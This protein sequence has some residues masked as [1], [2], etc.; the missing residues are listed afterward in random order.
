MTHRARTFPFAPRRLLPLVVILLL[1]IPVAPW[2]G[3]R[4]ASAATCPC[5]IWASSATPAVL[6]DSDTSAVEL[7]VKFRS[8]VRGFVTALRFY[9]G[10]GNNGTH[11][12]S[13]WSSAGVKLA[14]ATFTNETASGWQQVTFP[15]PVAVS[16]ATTYIASYYA[17]VGRYSVTNNGFASGVDNAPLHALADGVNG[18]N[19]IYRYGTGGGFPT[20]T[21]QATNYWVDVAFDTS[22]TDTT[23]PTL[24]ARTPTAGSTGVPVSSP[25][26]GTFSEPVTG[27]V[28]ALTGPAGNVPG[29]TSYD[30]ANQTVTFQ[31]TAALALSAT[32][33]ATVSAAK[34]AAGNTMA[35]TSWSFT[36]A[37]TA[38]GC[39]C[40]LWPSTTTPARASD[41]DN[42]AVEVGT[43]FS[44]STNG[45]VTALRFYKGSANVGTHVGHLWTASGSLLST[46]TF[47]G[48]TATGWQQVT[49]PAPVAVSAGT[50]YVASYFAPVGGYAVNNSYFAVARSSS[51]LQA[52]ADSAGT[53]NGVY[54]YGG[55]AFPSSTFQSSNYWVDVVFDTSAA[56][57]T[58]PTVTSRSPS[59]GATG[60]GT[61]TSVT[62]SFNEP[63]QGSTVVFT[64]SGP[65]GQVPSSV[66][67]DGPG[68]TATLTPS[69]LLAASTSY[70]ASVS[71]SDLAGNAMSAPVTWSF[72]TA[73]V[74]PPPPPSTG[75]VLVVPPTGFGR[76]LPEILRAEGLSEFA[77]GDL[78]ALTSANLAGYDVL[79]LGETPLSAAQVSTLTTWVTGG[80][81][82]IAMRPDKQL[83]G[84]LGL[85]ATLTTLADGY[86]LVNTGT[87]PGVGITDQVIQFHG[88]AD[89][90][91]SNGATTVATLYSNATTATINPAVTVRNVGT[92]GGQAAA[93]TYDLARSVV[94]TRQGNPAFAGLERDRLAPIRSDDLF[95]GSTATSGYLNLNKVAI[96]QAD[97][98]QRLL[99]NLI[100]TVNR[101]KKP[102][103]RFWYLPRMAK[104]VVVG[105]GDDHAN[106]GTA[107]RFDQYQSLSTPGCSV[108][109]WT[110]LR[111]TSYIYP[112]S[113]LTN[114]QASGYNANGFEVALHPQNGC[115]DYTPSSLE[116]D[117]ATQ[118]ASWQSTYTSLPAPTTSRYHCLVWS[119]WASQP[120][121]EA[122]HGIGLDANYYY[123]PGSWLGDRPG[124]MTGSGM[125]MHFADTDGSVIDVYQATTQ[126]T[127]ESGQSY[128]ATPDTLLNNAL[129]PLG[130]YG[131]FT[132]NMH[133]DNPTTF[134][135][136]QLISSAQAHGVSIISS[137]QMLTWL[138]GRNA[139]SFSN[140]TWSGNNLTFTV[141]PATGSDGLSVLLPTASPTGS[142]SGLT[143][144][145]VAV[146]YTSQR[147]KGLDYATFTGASGDYTATYAGAAAAAF[148]QSRAGMGFQKAGLTMEAT[149][150]PPAVSAVSV[151][152]LPDGTANAQW[153]TS[154]RTDSAVEL[155]Q[156][157]DALTAA[158][159]NPKSVTDHSVVVTGLVPGTTYFYRVR[160]TDSAGRTAT[161]SVHRF[162]QSAAGVADTT[163]VSFRTGTSDSATAVSSGR[164]GEIQLAL[165]RPST[166][167]P[168]STYLSRV[169]DSQQMVVW[170]R[171]TWQAS[172]PA[173]T[174]LQVSVRTGSRLLPDAT[175]TP[176]KAM[177]GSGALIRSAGR[178]VQYQVRMTTTASSRTPVLASIGFTHNGTLGRVEKEVGCGESGSTCSPPSTRSS[179]AVPSSFD[180]PKGTSPRTAGSRTSWVLTAL[181]LPLAVRPALAPHGRRGRRTRRS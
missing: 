85:T 136:D 158:G 41:S 113:P 35:T 50:A 179:A 11:V 160:S 9:K 39:P 3:V 181:L 118:L 25:V 97:E 125:P 20:N 178:Y 19:G 38:G 69:S 140:L 94:Y 139:S 40:S 72:T 54:R 115:H 5:T 95:W 64:L 122:A 176:F 135:D 112:N 121:T 130:Y 29:S 58:P 104:A 61:S 44:S 170:D 92:N 17:P 78:S 111:T 27:A 151:I 83:A 79:V 65:G 53:P 62:A 99:V 148:S 2:L 22:S 84:L 146:A 31:P 49:L 106:G 26:S 159:N 177:S 70:T 108:V 171:V 67:V 150:A 88:T 162:V 169:L 157:A 16:A 91:L 174:A 68:T 86:E 4:L 161:S 101:D 73:A 168:S 107:G 14:S 134:Q 7:G 172:V 96:P 1:V 149:P 180:S 127:D 90:Y 123:W 23:A 60:V 33:T 75:P 51:P 82:L 154:T 37:A 10:T 13:L 76:F 116:N 66:V 102:L 48:E 52:P 152:A 103:P 120:K 81:N 124:F 77:V 98:Q 74:A 8:D 45:F 138:T 147:I 132:A 28:V 128:P 93:F 34:D 47:S 114:S 145:G 131:A 55:S 155:G 71:A 144:G 15:T 63:V 57:R 143:R 142:L 24:T 56:D 42:S 36:T 59:A 100:E 163:A 156:S 164:D 21:Y 126:M 43:R 141:S 119:D 89:S 18:S 153:R 109:L 129:G 105:T 175:W 137:R 110:C 6:A 173:G 87:G 166:H 117:Y 165:T 30:S 46:A 133:T 32:Y 167:R 12:G 80:G